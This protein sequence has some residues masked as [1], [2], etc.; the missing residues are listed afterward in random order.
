MYK[1]YNM[2]KKIQILTDEGI[3]VSS[4]MNHKQLN[5]IAMKH[6]I[7]KGITK[8]SDK[9]LRVTSAK[10][11]TAST[12]N[13]AVH[14]YMRYHGPVDTTTDCELEKRNKLLGVKDDICYWCDVNPKEALDHFVP[15]CSSSY[16]IIGTS[17]KLNMFP[18]CTY[19]NSKLK[20]GK[21]PD[22]WL[23]E[24]QMKYPDKW[25]DAKVKRLVKFNMK[26]H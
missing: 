21:P 11:R 23:K 25:D 26:I 12:Q 2:K 19:C 6:G 10:G 15:V 13:G 14:T 3:S 16:N 8:K 18:S 1:S 17:C 24:L 22:V 4:N 9:K 20:R 5:V 7:M